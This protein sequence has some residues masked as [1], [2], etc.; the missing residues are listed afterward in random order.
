MGC[1]V[2]TSMLGP[3][4]RIDVILMYAGIGMVLGYLSALL[5]IARIGAA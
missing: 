1:W 4:R 3:E 5:G 2:E